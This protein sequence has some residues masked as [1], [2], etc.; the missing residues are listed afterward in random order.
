M[1]EREK[2]F[3]GEGWWVAPEEA[4]YISPGQVVYLAGK[5]TGVPEEEYKKQFYEAQ[6]FFQHEG[7]S[8]LNST[9]LPPMPEERYMPICMT[10]L[11]QA[12]AIALLPGWETSVG[13]TAEYWY[14]IRQGKN[15]IRMLKNKE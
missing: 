5:I 12:D 4:G 8:V 11:E 2:R 3:D 7:M 9:K 15:V 10:M 14:A 6:L 13:A 1:E